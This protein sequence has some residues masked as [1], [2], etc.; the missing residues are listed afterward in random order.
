MS[1][2]WGIGAAWEETFK[3]EWELLY[4]KFPTTADFRNYLLGGMLC[5]V[6]RV[7]L[8]NNSAP[9]I[10]NALSKILDLSL[11]YDAARAARAAIAAL[12]PCEPNPT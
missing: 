8:D 4:K 11:A 3:I 5:Q 12:A 7:K 1:G 2:L 9:D 6:F 10:A